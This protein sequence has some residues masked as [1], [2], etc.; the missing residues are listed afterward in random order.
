V[1]AGTSVDAAAAA[2]PDVVTRHPGE[3]GAGP[4]NVVV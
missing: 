2:V 4:S 3:V 1:T